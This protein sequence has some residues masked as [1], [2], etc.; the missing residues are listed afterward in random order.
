MGDLLPGGSYLADISGGGQTI[1][2]RVIEYHVEVDGQ[3][4]PEMFCLITELHGW[5][6]H[7]A[8][9]LAAACRWRWM[10]RKRPARG[11]PRSVGA[12]PS[13]GP[14]FR[15]GSPDTLRSEH[16]AWGT[17]CELVL[18]TAPGSRA[19]PGYPHR[20]ISFTAAMTTTRNGN[21]TASLPVR[22]PP[23]QP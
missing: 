21:A 5:R 8:D 22:D 11:L 4:V 20:E 10:D 1:R 12:G 6:T 2:M 14:I 7:P 19:G 16:A 17:F 18:A 9:V 3:D 23:R 13:T 15:S